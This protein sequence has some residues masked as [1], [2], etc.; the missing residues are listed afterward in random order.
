M[1]DKIA[2]CLWFD[3]QAEEAANFYVSLLPRLPRRCGPPRAPDYPS[4]KKGDVLTI[5][6]TLAARKF[7]GMN[8]GPHFTFNPDRAEAPARTDDRSRSWQGGPWRRC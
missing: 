4:G 7:V 8:G 5:E 3:G 1:S 6:F 2:P